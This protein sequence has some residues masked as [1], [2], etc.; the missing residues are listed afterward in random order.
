MNNYVY[1]ADK[2][3]YECGMKYRRVGKSGILLPEISL[4]MWHN[5]GDID[6]FSTCK[7][8]VHYAFDHGI[9]HFDLATTTVPQQARQKKHSGKSCKN[10]W[11]LTAMNCLSQ[12]K[13]DTTC[14]KVL[15]EP[16]THANIL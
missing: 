3:R 5:F 12:Q 8:I 10:Q 6:I 11:H 15:T 1:A 4:G 7:N 9:T 14:G 13:P 16:G 2:N